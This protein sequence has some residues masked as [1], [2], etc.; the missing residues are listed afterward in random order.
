MQIN[1]KE[2]AIAEQQEAIARQKMV[3]AELQERI[4]E[5]D[6]D[7]FYADIA[8]DELGYAQRGERVWRD[9]SGM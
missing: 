5:A 8:R 9:V 2:A 7:A 3:N 4:D 6:S 1:E